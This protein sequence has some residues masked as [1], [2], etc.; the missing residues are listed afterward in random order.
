MKVTVIKEFVDK[1]TKEL[2]K[3]GSSF[4]CSESRFKEIEKTGS[5]V[6]KKPETAK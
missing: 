1:H 6:V 2:H 3:V 5:F 4:D